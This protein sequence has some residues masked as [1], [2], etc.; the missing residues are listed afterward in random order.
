MKAVDGKGG[1][2]RP[3]KSGDVWTFPV[4]Q[5]GTF[6]LLRVVLRVGDLGLVRSH[7]MRFVGA[8]QLVQLSKHRKLRADSFAVEN[9]LINGLFL[10]DATLWQKHGFAWLAV[11]PI[12]LP[13]VEFPV[14]FSDGNDLYLCRGQVRTKLRRGDR[15]V[16][17]RCIAR[18]SPRFPEQLRHQ[19]ANERGRLST[20][21][22]ERHD[23]RYS[24]ARLE[25]AQALQ[26][27]LDEP[28]HEAISSLRG[29]LSKLA[30][31]IEG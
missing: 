10:G 12:T 28:Y 13:E 19:V 7:P 30:R 20:W 1:P 22:F 16:A 14:W 11:R 24:P 9:L 8:C 27:D 17:K 29:A 15:D 26:V 2:H 3:T 5:T 6:G 31:A 25:A 18:L 23:L 4:G 21:S